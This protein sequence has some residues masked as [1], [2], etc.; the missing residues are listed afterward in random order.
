MNPLGI[1]LNAESGPAGLG[2]GLWLCICN[3]LPGAV[4]GTGQEPTS[5]YQGSKKHSKVKEKE[6]TLK[7]N[8]SH[9]GLI[10]PA[11]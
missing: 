11:R 2:W 3:K 10:I 1:L 7:L 5:E 6:N 8:D 4:C 9:C